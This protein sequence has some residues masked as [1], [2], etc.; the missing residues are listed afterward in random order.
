MG[1]FYMNLQN[2]IPKKCQKF[3]Y[4]TFWVLEHYK[5]IILFPF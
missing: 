4:D 3:S 2:F 5:K 1:I